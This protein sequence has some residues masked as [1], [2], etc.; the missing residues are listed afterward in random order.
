MKPPSNTTSPASNLIFQMDNKFH[1]QLSNSDVL[2]DRENAFLLYASFCGDVV[3]TAAALNIDAVTLLKV[4]D[5]ERW[6]E[7]LAPI[8]NLTKSSR[9]GDVERGISRAINFCQAH[10]MRILIERA[11]KLMTNWSDEEMLENLMPESV[12]KAGVAS[13]KVS[14]RWLADFTVCMDKCHH[15]VYASL[16]DTATERVR[17]NDAETA[18]PVQDLHSLIALAMS[19]VGNSKTP[20]AMLL[21]SQLEVAESIKQQA[22]VPKPILD[23]S[24]VDDEH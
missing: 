24:F 16:N 7:K 17:R 13:K 6:T 19:G 11:L 15:L 10:R 3:K 12:S 1:P 4:I 22:V 21:D 9:P 14:T 18:G 2:I 23:D 20:R 5:S 8:L